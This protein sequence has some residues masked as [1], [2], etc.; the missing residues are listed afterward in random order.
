MAYREGSWLHAA[1]CWTDGRLWNAVCRGC[2]L[3]TD[4]CDCCGA[5]ASAPLP[6]PA[7]ASN[8]TTAA[9]D[10]AASRSKLLLPAAANGSNGSGVNSVASEPLELCAGGVEPGGVGAWLPLLLG[11]TTM[12]YAFFGLVRR[13]KATSGNRVSPKAL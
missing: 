6:T 3:S 1:V 7:L 5:A 11:L 9:G 12:I 4:G 10:Q 2:W 8:A 13:G